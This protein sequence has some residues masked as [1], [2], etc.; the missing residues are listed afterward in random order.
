MDA[1]PR[2]H[3]L[4][5]RLWPISL[6]RGLAAI[7][8]AAWVLTV[9]PATQAGLLR[10]VAAFWLVDGLIMLVGG[11]GTA[12]LA[13]NR[14]F[15][16]LRSLAGI[17]G[18]VILFALPLNVVF[19]G[20]EPGQFVL[21]LIVVPLVIG[22]IGLQI[23]AVIFDVLICFEVRRRIPGEWSLALASALSILFDFGLVIMLLVPPPVL[24]R[25][26]GAAGIIGGIAIIMG[27]LR[28]RPSRDTSL[29]AFPR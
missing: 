13:L 5:A 26:V 7:G 29:P 19:G 23:L 18:A 11:L 12:R 4:A 25:G 8:L 14:M 10:A 27:A 22:A 20:W 24:G 3:E 16:L 17:I 2:A 9:P 28:L 15:I 6:F 21:L 1:P